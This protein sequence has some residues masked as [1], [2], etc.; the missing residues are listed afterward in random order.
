MIDAVLV[1]NFDSLA[2]AFVDPDEGERWRLVYQEG[3]F[4]IIGVDD[5]EETGPLVLDLERLGVHK[6]RIEDYLE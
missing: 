3:V 2:H 4:Y 5:A 6:K 1:T